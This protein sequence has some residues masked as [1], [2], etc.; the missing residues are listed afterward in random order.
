MKNYVANEGFTLIEI[1]IVLALLAVLSVAVAPRVS[2]YFSS[3]KKNLYIVSSMISR[4]FDDSFIRKNQNYLV[5]HLTTPASEIVD[6]KNADFMRK[7][8]GISVVTINQEGLI[9]ESANPNLKPQMFTGLFSLDEVISE[10]GE[11][12]K[13]GAVFIPFHPEGYSENFVLYVTVNNEPMSLINTKFTK[14]PIIQY[15][16]TEYDDYFSK[17]EK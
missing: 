13:E 16:H 1:M 15:G 7:T 5:I 14:T 17:N 4:T 6:T 11:H 2:S 3:Q 8:N 9:S 10:S 12:R